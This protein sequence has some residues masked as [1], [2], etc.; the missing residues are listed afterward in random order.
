MACVRRVGPISVRRVF[1][2]I[3]L[4]PRQWR[5]SSAEWHQNLDSTSLKTLPNGKSFPRSQELILSHKF[6]STDASAALQIPEENQAVSRE[7][8]N[9][10]N[11][12]LSSEEEGT[13]Q[14][15]N[16]IDETPEKKKWKLVDAIREIC[17]V[18]EKGD[19]HTEETLTQLGVQIT[20]LL[21]KTV[22]DTGSSP[23]SAL[24]F[25][26][27]AKAQ[28]GFRH[29]TSTYDKLVDV[30]GRS[31]DF[32]TLQKVLSERFTECCNNSDKTFSFA[33]VSKDNPN[34]LNEVMEMIDR[35][36]I[37][38]RR[39]AYAKLVAFLFK[40]NHVDAVEVVL[41]K[42]ARADCAPKM[43]T[44]RPLIVFCCQKYRMDKLQWVFEMMKMNGCPPGPMRYNFILRV[45][46]KGNRF[47]EAAEL[48]E[49][50]AKMGCKPNAITYDIMI[51]AA[52]MMGRVQGALQLFDRLKEEGIS[53]LY[54]THAIL[55][56]GLF[57]TRGFNEAYSFLVQQ[58]GKDSILDL[59]NYEYLIGVCTK[60]G[61]GQEARHLLME[62]KAKDLEL[63]DD[64]LGNDVLQ[65]I[66]V[67]QSGNVV[68]L[69]IFH[70]ICITI[71]V[72]LIY[73]ELQLTGPVQF[74]LLDIC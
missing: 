15:L 47:E 29:N 16:K 3:Q 30:L 62:M 32:E 45:L 40:E 39:H 71:I 58:S 41:E 64:Q 7:E 43:F 12:A 69:L 46:C 8:E 11:K 20:P 55:L 19:A 67:S 65:K 66:Q 63:L 27:W 44:F 31:R 53:P 52:C 1:S 24:R 33:T 22:L 68:Q 34:L 60:S 73:T 51:Q 72:F 17:Q 21:V 28:P 25:F 6:Y 14:Q 36:E 74:G 2:T 10:E 37:S 61:R 50:M 5:S 42:M 38:A 57:Q 54:G 23:S 70:L 9:P 59:N 13:L 18:L 56:D 35:L 26:Q 48:L 49:S 4:R